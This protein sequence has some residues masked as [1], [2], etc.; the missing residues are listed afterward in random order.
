MSTNGTERCPSTGE[1]CASAAYCVGQRALIEDQSVWSQTFDG[2]TARDLPI[3]ISGV[4]VAK[5]CVEERM[6]GL[7]EV[8]SDDPDLRTQREAETVI[9]DLAHARSDVSQVFLT[10]P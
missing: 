3:E 7:R 10:L 4:L 1:N 5:Y 2:Q 9:E 8:V 6:D